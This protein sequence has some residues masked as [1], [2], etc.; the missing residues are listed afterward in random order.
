MLPSFVHQRYNNNCLEE[1]LLIS[2]QKD[3]FLKVYSFSALEMY[4]Y[5][6]LGHS[7]LH[8]SD[9]NYKNFISCLGGSAKHFYPTF[10]V[11]ELTNNNSSPYSFIT[12]IFHFIFG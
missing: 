5:L 9:G 11:D 3:S 8:S 1:Q 10:E 2:L 6:L 12:Y 7:L 4:E